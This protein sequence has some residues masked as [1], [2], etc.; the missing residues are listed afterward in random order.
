MKRQSLY[1]LDRSYTGK[2]NLLSNCLLTKVFIH[3]I[4]ISK[5]HNTK[6]VSYLDHSKDWSAWPSAQI[7]CTQD[8]FQY[9]DLYAYLTKVP[10][11][12][13]LQTVHFNF[14]W[15]KSGQ[16]DRGII[17]IGR[18]NKIGL[19]TLHLPKIILRKSPESLIL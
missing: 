5:M 8:D 1:Q 12:D 15:Q 9:I 17:K 2:I 3:K 4:A 14:S 7:S 18:K 10:I 11:I 16:M 19:A 13:F 6:V